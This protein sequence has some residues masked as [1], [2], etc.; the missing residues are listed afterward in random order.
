MC[1]EQ[2]GIE[3]RTVHLSHKVTPRVVWFMPHL[4]W[5]HK[6]S[7]QSFIIFISNI[8]E[9]SLLVLSNEL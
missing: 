3:E 2:G 6:V 1:Q 4:C 7:T 9:C 8:V 5:R